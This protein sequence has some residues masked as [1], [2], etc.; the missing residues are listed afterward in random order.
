M[1]KDSKLKTQ[2]SRLKNG[3]KAQDSEL[4]RCA[5]CGTDPI[6]QKYHDE[7]WG[8]EVRDDK[9]M[10]EFLILEGAQAGL[11]WITILRR[12]DNYRKAF[13]NFDVKK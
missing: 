9:T 5:W 7:E 6:Y 4:T 13:A 2:N 12:R 1:E 3:L 8:K 10:F 11:S